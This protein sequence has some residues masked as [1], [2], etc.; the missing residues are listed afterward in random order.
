MDDS[1]IHWVELPE[2]EVPE[3]LTTYCL[4]IT[5]LALKLIRRFDG[6]VVDF[7][8]TLCHYSRREPSKD[9]WGRNVEAAFRVTYPNGE[10][11]C[12][13]EEGAIC[14]VLPH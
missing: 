8:A 11:L 7:V 9:K 5:P 13:N 10:A 3:M 14:Y 1:R 6:D 12:Y 2:H 4:T